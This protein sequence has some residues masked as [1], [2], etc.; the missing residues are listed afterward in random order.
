MPSRMLASLVTVLCITPILTGCPRETATD[1]GSQVPPAIATAPDD[2]QPPPTEAPAGGGP[3]LAT[4]ATPPP[5]GDEWWSEAAASC[6]AAAMGYEVQRQRPS[7]DALLAFGRE[8]A[9]WA[10]YAI[11]ADPEPRQDDEMPYTDRFMAAFCLARD[12]LDYVRG[13]D[14]ALRYLRA[15][16]PEGYTDPDIGRPLSANEDHVAAIYQLYQL[17][18]DGAILYRLMEI[19]PWSDGALTTV[20]MSIYS[21]VAYHD[22]GGF[23]TALSHLSREQG[24]DACRLAARGLSETGPRPDPRW[25]ELSGRLEVIAR[26]R[27]SP[28]RDAAR[29][30]LVTMKLEMD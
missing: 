22:T 8:P 24:A 27:Q 18:R 16:G 17:R 19:A 1:A 28:L 10:L 29:D 14:I 7:P 25:V 2:T 4:P 21:Q 9:R 23:L 11:V 20:L 6:F 12:D 15:L 13:R 5:A 30:A 26:D 3:A